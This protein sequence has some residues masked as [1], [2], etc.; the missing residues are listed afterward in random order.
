MVKSV[1]A[2]VLITISAMV[3]L[4]I[5]GVVGAILFT[6]GLMIILNL[7]LSLFTGKAGLVVQNK[8][9]ILDLLEIWAGNLIGTGIAAFGILLTPQ[10]QSLMGKAQEIMVLR[11]EN[12]TLVNFIYGIFCGILMFSAVEIYNKTKNP[13]FIVFP[14]SV[15][16]LCGFNHCVAD[17]A[18]YWLSNTIV[19]FWTIVPTTLGNFVGCSLI[20]AFNQT[21]SRLQD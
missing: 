2:G 10:G 7:N 5:G 3:Y 13:V 15:F 4:T 20:P 11:S 12:G 9:G 17:M 6:V 16:I 21:G 14:V 8:I 1:L 19:G 18:Y